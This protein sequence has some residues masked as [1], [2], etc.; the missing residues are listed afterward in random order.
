MPRSRPSAPKAITY[1][2]D[3][4]LTARQLAAAL[5]T[6]VYSVQRMDLPFFRVG[7]QMRFVYGQ[8]VDVLSER[9]KSM[10]APTTTFGVVRG[11][12]GRRAAI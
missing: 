7:R 6:S 10:G 9:A 12:S 1:P 2:R 8:V 5:H 4:V 11:R 3:A